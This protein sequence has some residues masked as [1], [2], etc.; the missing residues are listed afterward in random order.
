MTNNIEEAIAQFSTNIHDAVKRVPSLSIYKEFLV[1][2]IDGKRYLVINAD[3]ILESREFMQQ[4]NIT[5]LEINMSLGYPKLS[6][7]FLREFTFIDH[8][9]IIHQPLR[10]TNAI[11]FLHKLKCLDLDSYFY[12]P[13][14]FNNFPLLEVCGIHWTPNA[15]NLFECKTLKILNTRSYKGHDVS[16]YS[17]LSNLEKLSI[18]NSPINNITKL[19]SLKKLRSLDLSLLSKLTS[20]KGIE[21]LINLEELKINSCTHIH[22]IEEIKYLINLTK[23]WLI[24]C[25]DV[26]SLKP[27]ESIQNLNNLLF[28]GTT[29]IV[30]GDLTP[31]TKLNKLTKIAF[32]NR[33]HYTHRSDFFTRKLTQLN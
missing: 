17:R 25:K 7:D 27:I 26:E 31:L 22:D 23:L 32:Q 19:Q 29:N 28:Y 9:A 4:E 33:K 3:K 15:K 16:E 21:K 6:I 2:D 20:L 8:L 24:D 12:A 30:D 14:D 1:R 18:I 13:L 10:E 5:G 11:N